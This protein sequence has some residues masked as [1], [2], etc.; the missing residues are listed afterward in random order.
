MGYQLSSSERLGLY[1]LR[2]TGGFPLRAIATQM[3]RSHRTI[4]HELNRNQSADQ[5]YQRD[6]EFSV[7]LSIYITLENEE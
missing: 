7:I 4:S 1:Q 5:I 3:G 6:W 2:Q